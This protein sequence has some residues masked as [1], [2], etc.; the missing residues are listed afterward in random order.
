MRI[1]DARIVLT[2]ASGGI[3]QALAAELAARG[4]RIG[5]VGRDLDKLRGLAR[6]LADSGAE[7]ECIGADLTEAEGSAA[8]LRQ[9]QARFG[10]VD[11]L[12]NNAGI[13]DFTEFSAADPARIE[14]VFRTNVLAPM[15]LSRALLPDM[16]AQERGQIVNV[17][18]IFGSIAFACFASYSASKFALR[19]FSEALR[20]ELEG[21][22]VG[23]TYV[24]PRAVRTD[25]N[26]ATVYRMAERVKMAMDPPEQV[27]RQIVRAIEQGRK[28]VYLGFPEA[29][30]VRINALLPRLVDM[31]LSN[32]NRIM[33]GFAREG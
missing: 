21:S 5:L 24:A 14:Q 18:S 4:A 19:G 29:L 8:V 13:T 17:G 26:S 25:L 23:V 30:F 3:G 7:T 22:G 9:M 32:Q 27:A 15:Q 2:G 16:L 28:D 1:H 11:I 31:A 33:R 20:R 10:G 6:R 12:I